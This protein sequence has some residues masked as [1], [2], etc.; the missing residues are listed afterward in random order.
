MRP[1]LLAA[2][3][4]NV[5][6]VAT[7]DRLPEPGGRVSASSISRYPGG[8]TANLACAA[9]RLGLSTRFFGSAGEDAEGNEAL[10]ELQELGVDTEGVVRS[11]RPTTM[12]LVLV[13]PGGNRAIVT[14]PLHFYYRPLEA[15][16]TAFEPGARGCL[17][18]DG[19]RFPE[20]LEI[21]DKARKAGLT[22]SA[23][24]DGLELS[25]LTELAPRIAPALDVAFLNR[26]LSRAL[27]EEPEAAA[28]KLNELGSGVVAVTL[29]SQ[30]ALVAG[31]G[32]M[33]RVSAPTVEAIDTT[34]AGDVFAGAFLARWLEGGT[35][36]EAGGFA[37][38]A[39]ALSVT[40]KG[41]RGRLPR[42][43]EVEELL[44]VGVSPERSRAR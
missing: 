5:D 8:M 27:D 41:A 16:L 43:S 9:S 35:A 20:A 37:A 38:V 25:E 31:G 4:L 15:A 29:G 33:V 3:Y 34:G 10:A 19:H 30:G 13:E 26:R 24:L 7:V 44:A 14:E 28:A 22:T 18:L 11:R 6:I 1:V 2:G 32:E 17:H 42:R 12:A 39:G 40:G 23:D 21:F 36:E